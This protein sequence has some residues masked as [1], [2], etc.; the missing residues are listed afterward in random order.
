M[1]GS[2]EAVSWKLGFDDG[3]MKG[4]ITSLSGEL[5]K[6]FSTVKADV[7]AI[8][9]LQ[10]AE[11]NLAKSST[12]DLA[13]YKAVT[14][15]LNRK[16]EAVSNTQSDII[17]LAGG[18]EQAARASKK[19][20]DSLR[21]SARTT[22]SAGNAVKE[23][24]EKTVGFREGLKNI[25]ADAA[26]VGGPI[27]GLIG[28]VKG[29]LEILGGANVA[30]IALAGGIGIV[31]G[32]AAYGAKQ[33]LDY[34]VATQE[35]NQKQLLM[36]QG[37][38]TLGDS[39][40]NAAAIGKEAQDAMIAVGDSSALAGDKL[41]ALTVSL[42][43]A[44]F[45]G[46]QLQTALG[47]AAQ[48]AVVQGDAAAE[49]FI[50]LA[51]SVKDSKGAV[52]ILAKNI[53]TKMGGLASAALLDSAVQAERFS[54]NIGALFTGVDI[55]P[56]QKA[57]AELVDTFSQSSA[58]GQRMRAIVEP[59]T[60]SLV[61]LAT[62]WT[63]ALQVGLMKAVIWETELETS[64]INLG[65]Q[66]YIMKDAV[67][68]AFDW[69]NITESG[70]GVSALTLGI[71]GVGAQSL[72]MVGKLN[73]AIKAAGGLKAIFNELRLVTSLY[74]TL[75]KQTFVNAIAGAVTG[76]KTMAMASWQAATAGWAALAPM[77]PYIAAVVGAGLAIKQ[78]VKYWTELKEAFSNWDLFSGAFKGMWEDFKSFGSDII[79][80]LIDGIT[81]KGFERAKD[82]IGRL[83]T[84][85]KNAFKDVLGIH[86]PSSVFSAYGENLSKGIEVG[87]DRGQTSLDRRINDMVTVPAAN[88]GASPS[89]SV[90]ASSGGNSFTFN[91][92]GVQGAED[93]Q[94]KMETAVLDVL[95]RIARN[96]GAA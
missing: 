48:V 54:K 12:P 90:Q 42:L 10:S 21:E 39:W 79:G 68:E 95:A 33:L 24:T 18:V 75:T 77:L 61:K 88:T 74:S 40:R 91:F 25:A 58:F 82:A 44:K 52:D 67:E 72:V 45:Q 38:A 70:L 80:G 5:K 50:K 83:G 6:L 30:A 27:G 81:G 47:A 35:A 51:A 8:K 13:A 22:Q 86:S 11:R 65:T 26:K 43:K 87:I 76:L 84:G 15:A 66:F 71:I 36:L 56:L 17:R 93:A 62:D 46:P 64:L 96:G 92:Y 49:E 23:A 59:L 4:T 85:I 60:Q 41:Q 3:S 32:A 7:D 63:F 53:D 34:A 9:E 94:E 89:A 28:R 55:T 14:D 20:K 19:F 69:K 78:I 37:Q 1:A 57:R 31:G 16:K 73:S 29:V 2:D